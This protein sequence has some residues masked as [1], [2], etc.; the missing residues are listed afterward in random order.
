MWSI[1][2]IG[3]LLAVVCA[4]LLRMTIF[5]GETMPFVMELPPYRVPTPRSV[6]IHMWQRGWM[7]LKKAGTVI[8]GIS[9]VLW[10]LASFPKPDAQDLAGLDET[11]ARQVAMSHSAMGRV[12]HFIEPALKPLG[13]DWKIGT[14]LIG[15][16][17]AK[18]VFVSQLSIVYAVHSQDDSGV[19]SV[20]LRASYSPLVGFCILLFCLISAPCVATLAVTRQETGSW[21]WAAFQFLGLTVLAYGITAIVF[22]LGRIWT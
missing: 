10:V 12:G 5:Q 6:V 20:K 4:K 9:V 14:A 15:S 21:R 22:Q 7:F 19:L 18:E 8:L 1:Y 16:L 13:F 11:Q 3:I 2:L 17:A